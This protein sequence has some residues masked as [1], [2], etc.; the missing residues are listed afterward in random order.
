MKKLTRL[1]ILILIFI[2][3]AAQAEPLGIGT[4]FSPRQ[5]EYLDQ[6]WKAVYLS[7]LGMGF[8]IIR[9]SAYWDRIEKKKDTYDFGSLDWQIKEAKKRKIPVVLTVGMKAPRWPEYHIPEWLL[10]ELDLRAGQELGRHPLL[11]ERTLKFI[12]KVVNRY[13]NEP[14]IEC[15]Q[16]E[17]EPLGRFGP[18]FW[19][20][21]KDFLKEEVNL[22]RSLDPH[23]RPILITTETYP[24]NFIR[25]IIGL[26]PPRTPIR[27][28]T[29][30]CDILGIDIYPVVGKK[31]WRFEYYVRT[32]RPER[33]KY[34]SEVVKQ[35]ERCGKKIWITE[36]QAEPWEAG[37]LVHKGPER[38]VSIRP[39]MIQTTLDEMKSLGIDTVL[40]WGAEYWHFRKARHGDQAWLKKVK[41]ILQK[42]L[43]SPTPQI[44]L[45]PCNYRR[46]VIY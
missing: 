21:G 26:I 22:V 19:W 30:L 40:L 7:I 13:K 38:P 5:S 46:F 24:N 45:S 11:K 29:L 31:F 37:K 28:S 41:D 43:G 23:R 44:L 27:D 8:D 35:T 18:H 16:V 4:T 34:F 10:A 33:L 20:I 1:L 14:I 3:A 25:F 42:N 9:L 12:K 39:D 32:R 15:W 36:L 17:N 2:Q 6:D